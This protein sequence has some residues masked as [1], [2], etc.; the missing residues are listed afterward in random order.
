MEKKMKNDM[1]AR[2]VLVRIKVVSRA[3]SS[4]QE[5]PMLLTEEA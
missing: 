2:V 5:G 4:F 1:A 3:S